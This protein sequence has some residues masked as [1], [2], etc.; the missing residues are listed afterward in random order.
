[1]SN[2]NLLESFMSKR[3]QEELLST[4]PHKLKRRNIF[5]MRVFLCCLA[6]FLYIRTK[7]GVQIQDDE[8]TVVQVYHPF[9]VLAVGR[10]SH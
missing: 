7:Q 10:T 8:Y 1:V 6:E 3:R 2:E 5:R 9:N 4:S